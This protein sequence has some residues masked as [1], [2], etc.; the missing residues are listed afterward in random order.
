MLADYMKSVMVH[1]AQAH[2]TQVTL[3]PILVEGS[4]H[5]VLPLAKELLETFS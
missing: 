1:H 5:D 3:N 4:G 2:E